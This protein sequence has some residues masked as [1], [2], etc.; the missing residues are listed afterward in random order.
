VLKGLD[1]LD[2]EIGE[3]ERDLGVRRGRVHRSAAGVPIRKPNARRLNEVTVADAIV[4]LLRQRKRPLHYRKIAETLVREKRYRTKS[5]NFLSTVAITIM[6]DKRIKRVE[7][8]VYTLRR[9]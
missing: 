9:R 2:R 5:R 1:R 6:R 3:L 7:P 8:G 4:K